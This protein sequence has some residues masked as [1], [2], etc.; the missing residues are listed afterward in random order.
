MASTYG[1]FSPGD[2]IQ[3]AWG[4]DI[5]DTL[6]DKLSRSNSSAQTVAGPVTFTQAINLTDGRVN[7]ANAGVL[8]LAVTNGG[9]QVAMGPAGAVSLNQFYGYLSPYSIH[10]PPKDFSIEVGSPVFNDGSATWQGVDYWSF[11]TDLEEIKGDIAVYPPFWFQKSFNRVVFTCV[12]ESG[13]QLANFAIMYSTVIGGT[14][15]AKTVWEDTSLGGG[16]TQGGFVTSAGIETRP[17]A[18]LN[19][20]EVGSGLTPVVTPASGSRPFGV[21][22]GF[23]ALENPNAPDYTFYGMNVIF[24]NIR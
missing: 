6:D 2:T 14:G 9:G 24:A 17:S 22:V 16:Y 4:N 1:T 23:R 18:T 7:R 21:K 12:L 15:S 19:T 10:I 3:A 20:D 8:E 13:E 11:D 5:N